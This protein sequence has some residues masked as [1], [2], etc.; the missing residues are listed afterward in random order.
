MTASLPGHFRAHVSAFRSEK[1]RR[2]TLTCRIG[3]S[4][5]RTAVRNCNIGSF[6]NMFRDC[7]LDA[8][9]WTTGPRTVKKTEDDTWFSVVGI[10]WRVGWDLIPEVN[11]GYG[12]DFCF[13]IE[14]RN[15]VCPRF[16]DAYFE[17]D[18][19]TMRELCAFLGGVLGRCGT[20]PGEFTEYSEGL[21]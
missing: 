1:G 12:D 19:D 4:E 6:V 7:L 14:R 11:E 16:W 17:M 10:S 2:L 21:F 3:D 13:F 9:S 15:A 8:L 18:E 20:D 5:Y